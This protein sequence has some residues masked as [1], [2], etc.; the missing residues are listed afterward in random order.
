MTEQ[1]VR[2]WFHVLST[3]NVSIRR[4]SQPSTR[5]YGILESCLECYA[6]ARSRQGDDNE[7]EVKETGREGEDCV[8]LAQDG[9]Q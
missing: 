6:G 7:R 2:I 1:H 8:H 4:A 3:N 5:F 9:I